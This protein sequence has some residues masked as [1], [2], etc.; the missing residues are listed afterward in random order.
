MIKVKTL[1]SEAI[2]AGIG[3]NTIINEGRSPYISD[4]GT[5]MVWDT[6]NGWVDTGI[7]AEGQPGR[8]GRDGRDG[9]DGA[10]GRDGAPGKDGSKGE[11]GDP[12]EKGDRGEQGIQGIPGEKGDKGDKGD[13]GNDYVLTDTDKQDIAGKVDAVSD[14]QDANG[15]SFVTDRVAKIPIASVNNLGVVR[16]TPY[17]GMS[18]LTGGIIVPK[19]PSTDYI[20]RRIESNLEDVA[21]TFTITLNRLDYAVKAAMCDGKGAAWTADEQKAARGRMDAAQSTYSLIAESTLEEDV[22]AITFSGIS[23]N[24]I[25]MLIDSPNGAI[26]GTPFMKIDAAGPMYIAASTNKHSVILIN[27]FYTISFSYKENIYED[28]AVQV[29]LS[30][31]PEPASN[32]TVLLHSNITPF[33]SGTTIRMYARL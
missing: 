21:N 22:K 24:E 23:G 13:P 20:D 4:R 8:D 9:A 25:V 1:T 18:V 11:K 10:P 14:V 33:L 29:S 5:W 31:I 27:R 19:S 26:G 28:A 7:R 17:R 30:G 32:M 12:G 2:H 6:V 3:N 16:V 15:N